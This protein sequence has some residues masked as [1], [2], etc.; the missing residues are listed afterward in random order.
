MLNN[1]LYD[2]LSHVIF[3]KIQVV[4]IY[5]QFIFIEYEKMFLLYYQIILYKLLVMFALFRQTV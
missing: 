1:Y 5:T 4:F 2:F 3:I